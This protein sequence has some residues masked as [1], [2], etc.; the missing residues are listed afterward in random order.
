MRLSYFRPLRLLS[1]ATLSSAIYGC[2]VGN[3]DHN[4][5]V[6]VHDDDTI[7][8][9]V[10]VESRPG[11]RIL[12]RGQVNSISLSD[13]QTL[14]NTSS[15]RDVLRADDVI[16]EGPTTLSKDVDIRDFGLVLMGSPVNNDYI[17]FN[18]GG[19]LRY[20]K[21]DLTIGD[22]QRKLGVDVVDDTGASFDTEIKYKFYPTLALFGGLTV[23]HFDSSRQS[24]MANIGLNWTP[25]EHMQIDIG[26]FRYT[27]EN[28]LSSRY[29]DTEDYQLQFRQID[30][31]STC[32]DNITDTGCPRGDYDS[33]FKVKAG[34]LKA[35]ITFKF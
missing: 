24:S 16:W 29:D 9:S 6:S 26:L 5:Q 1:V 2:G 18:I 27:Y 28:D 19:G 3:Y 13:S 21:G 8:Y 7:A 4:R 23:G 32:S 15:G 14:S 34:G 22:S 35:G 31:F 30:G 11:S 33:P 25:I 20:L 12:L 10:N 17:E